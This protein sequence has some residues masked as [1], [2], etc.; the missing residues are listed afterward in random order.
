MNIFTEICL[1]CNYSTFTICKCGKGLTGKKIISENKKLCAEN[2]KLKEMLASINEMS[3]YQVIDH[4]FNINKLL[5][6]L[7]AL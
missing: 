5:K 7:E 3:A 1:E 2:E 6:D 4:L